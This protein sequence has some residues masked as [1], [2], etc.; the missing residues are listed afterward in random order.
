[1]TGTDDRSVAPQA[2]SAVPHGQLF[3]PSAWITGWAHLLRSGGRVLDLACGPGRH[4]V[5]LAQRGFDVLAVDRDGQALAGLPASIRRRQVDLEQG[6]WPLADEAPFDGV[7]VTNYLHR[8]LW[9]FLL[10]ALAPGGVLLYQTFAAGNETVGKPSNPEFLLR[11][12]ELLDAVRPALR[13]VAYE[14]GVVDTPKTAFV[15]R[16]V[17]VRETGLAPGVAPARYPLQGAV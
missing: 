1:M 17:A 2:T 14:D 9:P 4:A 6:M 15:Q 3:P 13:V 5:W 16:I 8:P 7:V 11:P 12:G 10:D